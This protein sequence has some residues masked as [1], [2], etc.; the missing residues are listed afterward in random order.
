[1]TDTPRKQE[2]LDAIFEEVAKNLLKEL[3]EGEVNA[4]MLN[5][6]RQFLKDNGIEV[7]KAIQPQRY[8]VDELPHFGDEEDTD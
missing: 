5:V 6:A 2:I 3:Q 4:S 1:M 7:D 8:L